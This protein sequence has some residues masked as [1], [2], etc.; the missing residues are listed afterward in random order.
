MERVGFLIPA[1][2][3]LHLI[4]RRIIFM[5]EAEW[6]TEILCKF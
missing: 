1:T 2:E 4:L 3:L 5:Q 6:V